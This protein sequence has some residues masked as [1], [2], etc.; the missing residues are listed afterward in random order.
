[1]YAK[2]VYNGDDVWETEIYGGTQYE[3]REAYTN[4]GSEREILSHLAE[5]KFIPITDSFFY[6]H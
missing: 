5:C 6:K 3:F 2:I 1:M 4:T